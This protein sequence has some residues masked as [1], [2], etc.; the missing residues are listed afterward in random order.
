ME[1]KNLYIET[2]EFS[3]LEKLG[4]VSEFTEQGPD[5]STMTILYLTGLADLLEKL[6]ENKE[7]K[8]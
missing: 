6:T 7:G 8:K 4:V 3:R 2:E 1:I 5:G